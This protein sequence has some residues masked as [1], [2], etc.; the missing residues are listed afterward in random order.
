MTV[1]RDIIHTAIYLALKT[2]LVS[3]FFTA[4]Y[5]IPVRINN[6]NH[7]YNFVYYSNSTIRQQYRIL[8]IQYLTLI[9]TAV[10]MDQKDPLF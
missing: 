4:F 9:L 10:H 1:Y 2:S 5:F 7:D 8:G 3:K 6:I